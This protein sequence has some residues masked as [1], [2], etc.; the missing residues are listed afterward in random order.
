MNILDKEYKSGVKED[1]KIL[2]RQMSAGFQKIDARFDLQ[3]ERF[4]KIDERFDKIDERFNKI[5][6]RFATTDLKISDLRGELRSDIRDTKNEIN[7]YILSLFFA[8]I[9]LFLAFFLKK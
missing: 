2:G 7:R 3:D 5:D 1:L 9:L 8:I 6:A 4:N